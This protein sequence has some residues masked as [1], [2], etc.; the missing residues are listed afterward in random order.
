MGDVLATFRSIV[1]RFR[2]I[3]FILCLITKFTA[4][5]EKQM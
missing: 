1:R 5:K 2:H 3:Y 4:A